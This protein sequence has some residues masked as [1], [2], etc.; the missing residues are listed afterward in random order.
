MAEKKRQKEEGDINKVKSGMSQ[1]ERF[2]E[3]KRMEDLNNE[4][5]K[6][7]EAWDEER[8]V[9]GKVKR[10]REIQGPFW[11]VR[12]FLEVRTDKECGKDEEVME[13]SRVPEVQEDGDKT[14]AC[15]IYRMNG[16]VEPYPRMQL[17]KYLGW[18]MYWRS[19]CLDH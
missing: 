5:L 3:A 19:V 14:S 15:M 12:S 10:R 6:Q 9:K 7:W 4:R 18:E 16:A 2:L 13:V 11:R 17:R 1:A 8:R